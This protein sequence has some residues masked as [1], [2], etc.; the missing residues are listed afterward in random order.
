V[1]ALIALLLLAN[2]LVFHVALP[3]IYQL[4]VGAVLGLLGL[5][6]GVVII[7]VVFSVG[8]TLWEELT[9]SKK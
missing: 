1:I 6:V 9:R 2:H 5:A 4:V 3:I 7:G 8:L